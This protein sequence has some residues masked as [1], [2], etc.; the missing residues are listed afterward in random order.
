MG[1][2]MSH[3]EQARAVYAAFAEGDIPAV[4]AA[5]ST[6]VE[7]TE[8]LGGPYGGVYVGPQAVLEGVFMNIGAEWERFTAEP[9]QYVCDGETVVVLGQYS[10]TFRATGKAF[11]APFAHVWTFAGDK[12]CRFQQYTDTHLHRQPM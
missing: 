1:H 8:A 3:L 5:L 10:A 12:A 7:W 4:L 2:P 11:T 6:D 9:Q